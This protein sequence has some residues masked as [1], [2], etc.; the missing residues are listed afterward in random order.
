MKATFLGML[1]LTYWAFAMPGEVEGDW[2][3][4]LLQR[5][6]IGLSKTALEEA[7]KKGAKPSPDLEKIFERLSADKFS[8]REKA[9]E[10]LLK[11][12]E[13]ALKWLRQHGPSPDP[14]AQRRVEGIKRL[15]GS[16]HR[17][18][19]EIAVEHAMKSLLAEGDERRADTGGLYFEW[20]GEDQAKLGKEYR[21]FAFENSAKRAGKVMD[22]QLVF[23]GMNGQDGDQRLVLRSEK[24]PGAETFGEAFQVSVK[25]R[26]ESQGSG[27]W[28]LGITIGKVRALYHPGLKGGSFRFER[29]DN[30]AYLGR[31][32]NV[33]FTPGEETPQWMTVRVQRLPDEKVQLEVTLEE[34][35]KKGGRFET[36]VIVDADQVGEL[37]SVSLDRSGRTGGSAYFGNFTVKL[38]GE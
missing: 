22:G 2:R 32:G 25:L 1:G 20:F 7:L 21:Q 9:Q 5:E 31:P 17:K 3:D 4:E 27:A 26:G 29:I 23:S 6:G 24:W 15:L 35:G 30:H 19:R 33:G 10:E 36:L 18:E 12:G 13:V 34:D 16:L 37:N 38:L 28:H 11:G 14:E 8:E